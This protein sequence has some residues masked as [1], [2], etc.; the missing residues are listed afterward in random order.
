[1]VCGKVNSFFKESV[2]WLFIIIITPSISCTIPHYDVQNSL[3]SLPPM[4]F[5]NMDIRVFCSLQRTLPVCFNQEVAKKLL[6]QKNSHY[7]LYILYIFIIY[8]IKRVKKPFSQEHHNK[9]LCLVQQCHQSSKS[10][11]IRQKLISF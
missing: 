2:R 6:V 4:R 3:S 1:M 5:F 7:T 10:I 11:K 9:K 8:R